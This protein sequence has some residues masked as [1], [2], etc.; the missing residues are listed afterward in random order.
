MSA[1]V[2]AC[3]DVC[4][5]SS[6]CGCLLASVHMQACARA[7]EH[8]RAFPVARRA[9]TLVSLTPSTCVVDAATCSRK[10]SIF[11]CLGGSETRM[12]GAPVVR[13][14]VI[15]LRRARCM[16]TSTCIVGVI[17][18]LACS[19]LMHDVSFCFYERARICVCATVVADE[20]VP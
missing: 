19:L 18:V 15:R 10:C 8:V 16:Y 7:C 4:H 20:L 12:L 5:A 13:A 11:E 9:S 6:V 14:L 17:E 2:C 3:V 1:A